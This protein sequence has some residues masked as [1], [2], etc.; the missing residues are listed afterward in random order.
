[1]LIAPRIAVAATFALAL[2]EILWEAL[3]APLPGSRWL[4][5]K[6]LPLLLLLPGVARGQRRARQ[7]LALALPFYFAEG[8]VRALTESGRH[9]VVAATAAS[10]ATVAFAAML[11][12]LRGER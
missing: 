6:A 11:V 8:L 12:W 1:L 3:L 10:F 9:A 5:I 2:L 4:A 7:W